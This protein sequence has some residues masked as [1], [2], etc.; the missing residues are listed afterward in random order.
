MMN[1]FLYLN[2]GKRLQPFCLC[3]ILLAPL[4]IYS[5]QKHAVQDFHVQRDFKNPQ[6]IY[7][8]ATEFD[9]TRKKWV[10]RIALGG[11]TAAGLYLGV[12]WY[13]Q[14]DLSHFHFFDDSREWQQMDKVGHA[15]GG[16]HASKWMIDLYRWSGMEKKEA[17]LKGGL[18]GF[19]AMTSIEV[20]DGF[21]EKW[22]ASMSDVGAN[23]I[24][25]GLAIMNQALWN[26]NRIQLKVS[27]IRSEYAGD[28]EFEDLFG[29]SLPEYFLKDYNGQTLWLSVRVHSFLP[30]GNFKE[31][32]PRWLN[33]AVGY[34]AQG[35][36]G[37]YGQD[38]WSEI[39][40]REYRQFYISPDIDLSNIKTSSGF[41]NALLNVASI[42][43]IPLP[44]LEVDK[45]GLRLNGFR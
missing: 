44:A 27:Y 14:E 8:N 17:M 42:I 24:G 26:E 22:G 5:Q 23:A 38:S 12:V 7:L 2:R 35:L 34:G 31:K 20:L 28:P 25:S 13:A 32:Y 19:L 3:F 43:R 1:I 40:E 21:G 10:N 11:Y 29:S 36:E 4:G 15:L 18:Y 6:S 9:S 45:N 30:E 37:G 41:L 33:W 39:N 16:Y